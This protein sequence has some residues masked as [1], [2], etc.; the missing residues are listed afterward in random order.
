MKVLNLIVISLLVSACLNLDLCKDEHKRQLSEIKSDLS[1]SLDS[2]ELFEKIFN[3]VNNPELIK[4]QEVCSKINNGLKTEDSLLSKI[5]MTL[6][7][8]SKCAQ[9]I[10]PVFLLLDE[11][12]DSIKQK[13]WKEAIMPAIMTVLFAKQ[14]INDC[15]MIIQAIVDMWKKPQPKPDPSFLGLP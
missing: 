13:H 7:Y 6:V 14:G 2:F 1:E 5:G 12:V 11:V 9:E 10:G 8:E 4:N 15:R 3:I